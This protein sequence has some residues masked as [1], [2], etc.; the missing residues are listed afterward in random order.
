MSLLT[1][2][3]YNELCEKL[4]SY[5]SAYEMLWPTEGHK[6]VLHA[7][8]DIPTI[9][10]LLE[11]AAPKPAL[12]PGAVE[13][14]VK[15]LRNFAFAQAYKEW[16]LSEAIRTLLTALADLQAEVD[17]MKYC[18]RNLL[19]C[20]ARHPEEIPDAIRNANIMFNEGK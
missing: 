16:T 15:L 12:M 11:S 2:E 13:E 3:K 18:G 10:A 17:E 9:R 19:L 20:L 4:R 7:A 1:A 5:D 8:L 6:E 14:A